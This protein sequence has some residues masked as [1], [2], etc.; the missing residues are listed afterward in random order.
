MV[1]DHHVFSLLLLLLLLQYRQNSTLFLSHSI[2]V[3]KSFHI[4]PFASFLI[5]S[6]YD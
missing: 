3:I 6:E 1:Y 4:L 5:V 2:L